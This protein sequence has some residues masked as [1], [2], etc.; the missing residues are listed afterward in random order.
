MT[1][2]L[3]ALLVQDSASLTVALEGFRGIAP[4]VQI[5]AVDGRFAKNTTWPYREPGLLAR[6]AREEEGLPLWR[7]FQFEIDLM[8][9]PAQHDAR[10]FVEAGA[11]RMVIHRE[12]FDSREAL[13]ELQEFRGGALGLEVGLAYAPDTA[14]DIE[15][16][17]GLFDFVQCM[18]IARV[19]FQ[20]EPFDPRVL[21]RV[22]DLRSRYPELPLQVDGAVDLERAQAL[23]AAGATRLAVGS[24]LL[25]ASDRKATYALLRSL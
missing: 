20:G 13:Q 12:S 18:G 4:V 25:G 10:S 14:L 21:E 7:E 1:E 22:R 9:T 15:A 6:L 19:G 17:E 3:P 2:I 23:T 8:A 16:H 11:S 5:D 24:F